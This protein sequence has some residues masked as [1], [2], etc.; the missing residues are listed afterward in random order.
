MRSSRMTMQLWMISVMVTAI[1]L[2]AGIVAELYWRLRS[3]QVAA[4]HGY[5]NAITWWDEGRL[6]LVKTILASQRL[7]EAEY[8]ISAN[9]ECRVAA[10]SAHLSRAAELIEREKN[11]PLYLCR[12]NREMWIGEAEASLS[13]F[14]SRLN[15]M[16][17]PR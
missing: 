15:S 17:E 9:R 13:Q 2:K 10:L 3:H 12:D 8:A 11:D 4:L 5:R 14:K 7:M 6:D 1:I 16:S